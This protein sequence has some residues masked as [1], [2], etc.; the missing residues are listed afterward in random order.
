MGVHR[1]TFSLPVD[2]VALGA[3]ARAS[4]GVLLSG[5]SAVV[6]FAVH[7]LALDGATGESSNRTSDAF[8]ALMRTNGP[9]DC[10]LTINAALDRDAT[11]LPL[12]ILLALLR[13]SAF[14]PY[15][16]GRCY[17]GLEAAGACIDSQS[18]DELEHVLD[19]IYRSDFPLDGQL[20][21]SYAIALLLASAGRNAS[22]LTYFA[23]SRARHGPT[24]EGAYNEALCFVHLGRDA[25]ARSL[26]EESI[27][28]DPT[29][30]KTMTLRASLG[31]GR[32]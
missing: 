21:L 30:E 29:F 14:D 24:A 7:A 10:Y 18:A 25:E 28:I 23:R 1:G 31:P 5:E 17:P 26:L 6:E 2:P 22:A 27:T 11:E 32:E 12:S 19:A 15:V 4:D 8:R 13:V 16:F 9:E 20:D 3:F